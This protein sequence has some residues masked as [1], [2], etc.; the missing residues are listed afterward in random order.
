MGYKPEGYSSV[1]PY[2]MVESAAQTIEFLKRAFGAQELQR[3]PNRTGGTMHAEV[4]IDDSVIMLADLPPDWPR[5]EAHIHIYVPD[6]DAT[7]RRAIEAGAQPVQEPMKADDPDRRAGVL[8]GGGT[9][10]WI[11][12]KVE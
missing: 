4:R 1:S 3:V 6:V 9:T 7:Y 10:W 2:I 11:A 5:I 12:T 8:D